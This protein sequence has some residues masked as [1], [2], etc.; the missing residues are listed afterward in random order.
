MS[1]YLCSVC[2]LYVYDEKKGDTKFGLK[3]GTSFDF[4]P[5]SFL[6][7]ICKAKKEFFKK[8][9][10][11]EEEKAINK[12]ITYVRK[13]TSIEKKYNQFVPAQYE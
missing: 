6:C 4:I 12:Y 7:P 1:V 8:L 9:S 5:K 2:N 10:K 3:P 11:N 13:N